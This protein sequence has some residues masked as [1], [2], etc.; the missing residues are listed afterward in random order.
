MSEVNLP[1]LSWVMSSSL[2]L[3]MR[4]QALGLAVVRLRSR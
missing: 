4:E 1:I 3:G 2:M